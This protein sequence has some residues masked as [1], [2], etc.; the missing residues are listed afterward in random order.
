MRRMRGAVQ[1][2]ALRIFSVAILALLVGCVAV[3][4]NQ[5][6][7]CPPPSEVVVTG[8]MDDMM[9]YYDSLRKQSS[10]ELAKIYDRVKQNFGQNKSDAN[11]IRLALLLTLPN[12]SFRDVSAALHL[13]NDWPRDSKHVN[14]LQSFRNLLAA[15]LAEQQRLSNNL[16][17]ASQKLKEE[18]KRADTLQHQIDAIKSMEKNLIL[19]EP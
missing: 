17:E 19:I 10:S 4:E 18:Q 9:Q 15:L 8:Q 11:R 7:P 1:G 12:T 6:A 13:L 2:H 3:P 5:P 14:N 16:E